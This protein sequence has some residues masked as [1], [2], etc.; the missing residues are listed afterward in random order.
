MKES[1]LQFIAKPKNIFLIDAVGALLTFTLLFLV[2]RTFNS[3]FDLSKTILEYLSLLAL[4]FSIYS[5]TCFFLAKN[6]WKL[7]LK[8]ICTANILYCILTFGILLYHYN[9]I[10]VF[11]IV[12]FL[13]EIVVIACL[14][15]LEIKTIKNKVQ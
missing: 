11:G 1:I 8:I 14:V 5:L 4:L 7:Y 13:G 9:S 12:Y 6:N 15:F 10:S 2:L 3:Y